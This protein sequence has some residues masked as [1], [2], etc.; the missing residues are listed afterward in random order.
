MESSAAP[1][2]AFE[3][4][5]MVVAGELITDPGDQE[6]MT[7]EERIMYAAGLWYS[8]RTKKLDME[9]GSWSHLVSFPPTPLRHLEALNFTLEK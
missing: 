8:P 9:V 1:R 7:T 5:D 6:K 3:E 2:I 4:E